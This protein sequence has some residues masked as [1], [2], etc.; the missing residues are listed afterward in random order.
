M[1]THKEPVMMYRCPV[2]LLNGRD[3][4]LRFDHETGDLYCTLC[5]FV[6]NEQQI[7]DYYAVTKRRYRQINDK[8]TLKQI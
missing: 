8:V 6:G 3:P 2:C 1:P 7:R 4:A 5:C